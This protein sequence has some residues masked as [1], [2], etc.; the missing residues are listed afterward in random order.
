[1]SA[2]L[3]VTY[4]KGA[5]T[6]LSAEV[7]MPVTV[8]AGNVLTMFVDYGSTTTPPTG[9]TFVGQA[10][11][12]GSQ[13]NRARVFSKIANGTEG[14]TQVSIATYSGHT[15]FIHAVTRYDVTSADAITSFDGAAYTK[16]A[17]QAGPLTF[18]AD[19]SGTLDTSDNQLQD[20]SAVD[21]RTHVFGSWQMTTISQA[22]A[23]EVA[24][25]VLRDVTHQTNRSFALVDILDH[26][27]IGGISPA[28][29]WS[30]GAGNTLNVK[31]A[32]GG[33]SAPLAVAPEPELN[34]RLLKVAIGE[35]PYQLHTRML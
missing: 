15:D 35:L 8:V 27:G 30:R 3:D 1:M 34:L 2:F 19:H 4:T 10:I 31:G 13:A 29:T 21:T 18:W 7:N 32:E 11:D 14:G 17:A 20:D 24:G 33:Y 12:A 28:V 16:I 23:T 9:W 22:T 25:S 26:V 5:T 6:D